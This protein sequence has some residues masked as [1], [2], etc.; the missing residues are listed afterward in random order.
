MKKE[1]FTV[2]KETRLFVIHEP[3]G[4][5]CLGFEVLDTR[6]RSLAA[7]LNLEWNERKGTKKAYRRYR[8]IVD[9]ARTK[10]IQTGWRSKSELHPQL[11]GLEGRRI[12]V[13]DAGGKVYR[14]R[15]GKSTGFIPVHLQVHNRRSFGGGAVDSRPFK[16]VTIIR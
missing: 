14:F 1:N 4:Y 7:E 6:A 11:I 15:V 2:N 16:R 10:N 9:I 12:E 5:S 13:E 8:A 3:Y